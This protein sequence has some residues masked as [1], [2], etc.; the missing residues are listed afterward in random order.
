MLG[1]QGRGDVDGKNWLRSLQL[2]AVVLSACATPQPRA[3]T[4][5]PVTT[6]LVVLYYY[7]F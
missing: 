7:I 5:G 4:A 1:L 6:S 3:G 2:L